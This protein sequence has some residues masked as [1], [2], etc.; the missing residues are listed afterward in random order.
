MRSAGNGGGGERLLVAAFAFSASAGFGAVLVS[1]L[2][3]A[4]RSDL[5]IIL[6]SAKQAIGLVVL[7]LLITAAIALLET[8]GP[9]LEAPVI[10]FLRRLRAGFYGR[11]RRGRTL[12]EARNA[13]AGAAIAVVAIGSVLVVVAAMSVGMLHWLRPVAIVLILYVNLR[14]CAFLCRFAKYDP[15][16]CT[17]LGLS[18]GSIVVSRFL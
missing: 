15:V 10:R 7:V 3:R 12:A 18:Y 9:R 4:A 16:W 2:A 5:F 11:F 8:T 13:F 14:L 1:G 17:A 6:P